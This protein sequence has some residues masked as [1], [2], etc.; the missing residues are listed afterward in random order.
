MFPTVAMASVTTSR[1]TDAQR[2]IVQRH[3]DICLSGV[4]ADIAQTVPVMLLNLLMGVALGIFL[5]IVPEM[6]G[7]RHALLGCVAVG[8]ALGAAA[9]VSRAVGVWRQRAAELA[10]FERDMAEATVET[11][12]FDV[13]DAVRLGGEAEHGPSYFLALAPRE[14]EV[15]RVLFLNDPVAE[16]V[17]RPLEWPQAEN[18]EDRW[19]MLEDRWEAEAGFPRRHVNLQRTL[20]AGLLVGL[21]YEGDRVAVSRRLDPNDYDAPLVDDGELI[22]TT[23]NEL[24][25]TMRVG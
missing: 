5:G 9:A 22:E 3:I 1:M 8:T 14:G 10:R 18:D 20:H 12:M 16:L 25:E 15:P 6:A 13:A 21:Q 4:G 23:L 19:A 11:T 7:V 24:C 17:A 2:L